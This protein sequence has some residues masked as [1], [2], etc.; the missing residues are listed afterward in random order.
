MLKELQQRLINESKVETGEDQLIFFNDDFN[1][2][3]L[4]ITSLII[5]CDRSSG[6][7]FQGALIAHLKEKCSIK[8]ETRDILASIKISLQNKNSTA[9]IM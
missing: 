8:N 7:V 2:F 9:K 6:Q 3:D 4:M 5:T 1:T